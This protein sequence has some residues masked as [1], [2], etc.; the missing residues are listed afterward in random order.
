MK[1]YKVYM[2]TYYEIEAESLEEAFDKM[3]NE[4][5]SDSWLDCYETEEIEEKT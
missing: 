1:L 2:T 5:I 3:T 4:N